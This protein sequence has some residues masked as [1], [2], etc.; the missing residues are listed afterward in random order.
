[1]PQTFSK[2]K[3]DFKALINLHLVFNC[4][5]MFFKLIF[6]LNL[7]HTLNFGIESF[8]FWE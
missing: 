8:S 1:M 2:V 3:D 4:S 7:I 6:F 5:K